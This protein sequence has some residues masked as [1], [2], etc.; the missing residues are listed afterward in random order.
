MLTQGLGNIYLPLPFVFILS[1]MV[2]DKKE[3]TNYMAI[4]NFVS[5]AASKTFTIVVLG[6]PC[7]QGREQINHVLDFL[8]AQQLICFTI[9]SALAP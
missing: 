5:S 7:C 6:A 1:A 4:F 3:G 2:V 8:A 9:F